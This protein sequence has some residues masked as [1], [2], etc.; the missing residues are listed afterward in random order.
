MNWETYQFIAVANLALC[1]A[2][3]WSC[4][5]RLNSRVS[6]DH[7]LAR[8]RYTLLL[9]GA[10]TSGFQPVLFGTWPSVSTVIFTAAVLL[11]LIFNAMRWGEGPAPALA[12]EIS[13]TAIDKTRN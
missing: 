4:L 8:V 13:F 11:F 6:R 5:C 2:I 1:T 12:V 10:F 9:A 3:G 7:L